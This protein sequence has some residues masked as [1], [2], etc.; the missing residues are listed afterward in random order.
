MGVE[1]CRS[2]ADIYAE[3]APEL[4]RFATGIVGPADA[5]DVVADAFVRLLG[6][7]VWSDSSNHRA[8]LYRRVWFDAKSW[9]RASDRR[10]RREAKAIEGTTVE[11]PE[12][13][14]EISRAVTQLTPQQRAVVFLTY[15]SDMTP[16]AIAELLDVSEGTVRK[17][18]ARARD[19]LRSVL[20]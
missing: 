11:F 16:G 9:L 3:L 13:E 4:V 10:R 14:P 8:L 7:P 18:L 2:D 20:A 17:Q 15:W 1:G 19:R 12:W 6:T 5:P